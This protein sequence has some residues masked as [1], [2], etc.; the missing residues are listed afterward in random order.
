MFQ[1]YTHLKPINGFYRSIMYDLHYENFSFHETSFVNDII[2]KS[3]QNNGL[4]RQ[5]D[6]NRII[7]SLIHLGYVFEINQNELDLFP[8]M[9]MSWDYPSI[10][11]N[12]I[13]EADALV[14]CDP[15]KITILLE[16]LEIKF[17]AII[18]DNEGDILAIKKIL[19]STLTSV[20]QSVEI[21]LKI[22]TEKIA[23]YEQLIMEYKRIKYLLLHSS[24]N[25][26]LRQ[27]SYGNEHGFF[28]ETKRV[29]KKSNYKTSMVH[30]DT[31]AVNIPLF[32]ES[33]AHHTYF[34]RKLYIG[35]N[36]EIKN[37]PE[38][39]ETFGNINELK[40]VEELKQ[41]IATPEFQKYWFVHKEL[42][43][44]CK[45]CEFRHM[46]VDNRLP[47]QR[48]DGSWYHK[49]ECNYNPYICKWKEEEGYQTL[50]D[51]GVISN[52]NGFSINHEKIAAINKILWEE[53]ETEN[54]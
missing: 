34:N 43:D 39:E 26:L 14:K 21:I 54:A 25:E 27:I 2:L 49:T 24:H 46:C 8:Q 33:Q 17:L 16:E 4:N 51:I 44:V 52:E 22:N 42:C 50:E 12:I 37:A 18:S 47:Y 36:G 31:F 11:T 19:L 38:C 45:E 35:A 3:K 48:K 7:E 53:E 30:Y 41:I 5:D 28:A 29:L 15:K 6:E 10:I 40:N 13:I 1:L 23:I 9:N 20:I 32:T